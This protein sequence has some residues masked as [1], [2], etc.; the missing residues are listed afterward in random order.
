[1]DTNLSVAYI[2]NVSEVHTF[3]LCQERPK[4]EQV[5]QI[6]LDDTLTDKSVKTEKWNSYWMS[7]VWDKYEIGW[8]LVCLIYLP[9]KGSRLTLR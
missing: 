6:R 5:D 7:I 3:T 8:E 1:M 4:N 2:F 9:S